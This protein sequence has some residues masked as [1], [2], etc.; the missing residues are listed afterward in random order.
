MATAT[1]QIAAMPVCLLRTSLIRFLR[2]FNTNAS[3]LAYREEGY[4]CS[5]QAQ[6]VGR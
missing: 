1:Q 4:V 6:R 3:N 2:L 5:L